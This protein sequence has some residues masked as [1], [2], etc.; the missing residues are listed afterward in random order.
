M[1]ESKKGD[2]AIRDKAILGQQRRLKQATQFTHKDSADLLPLDGLKRLG[3]SKDLVSGCQCPIGLFLFCYWRYC[4][5]H[6]FYSL[7]HRSKMLCKG[8]CL[9]SVVECFTTVCPALIEHVPIVPASNSLLSSVCCPTT[10]VSGC[11][12][13]P[14]DHTLLLVLCHFDS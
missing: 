14:L 8:K 13:A 6:E 10:L 3:T 9:F 2:L 5:L 4:H 12:K 11:L 7:S 1:S